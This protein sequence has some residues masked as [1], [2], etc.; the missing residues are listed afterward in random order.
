MTSKELAA[1]FTNLAF[2]LKAGSTVHDALAHPAHHLSRNAARYYNPLNHK[3]LEGTPLADALKIIPTINHTERRLIRAAESGGHLSEV[4]F[5]LGQFREQATS[6]TT[7]LLV[8]MI[9]P[10]AV[11]AVSFGALISLKTALAPLLAQVKADGLDQVSTLTK[12]VIS[13]SNHGLG[14][15]MAASVLIPLS[16][17][18]L[19]Y[20]NQTARNMLKHTAFQL[21]IIR[22]LYRDILSAHYL[23]F[24]SLLLEQKVSLYQSL[25]IC[26]SSI[27]IQQPAQQLLVLEQELIEGAS[28]TT[29][30]ANA[31]RNAK[32]LSEAHINSLSF[33]I[34]QGTIRETATRCA[35]QQKEALTLTIN[36][37]VATITP[38]LMILCG[39]IVLVVSYALLVPLLTYQ[40]T[41]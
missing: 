12:A 27:S 38:V 29:A 4:L 9:Y 3:L 1:L 34:Q 20:T 23:T 28:L 7:T 32:I 25:S 41:P 13:F 19:S 10:F 26:R 18:M 33:A 22:T 31:H 8:N 39:T 16:L 37:I 35:T 36:G 2:S 6:I 15:A 11:V 40:T 5:A 30:F 14:Y 17:A 24:F 21:P